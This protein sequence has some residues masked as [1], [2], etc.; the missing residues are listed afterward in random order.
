MSIPELKSAIREAGLDYSDCTEKNELIERARQALNILSSK[1][2]Q[3]E[4]ISAEGYYQ[5]YHVI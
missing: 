3:E 5:E 1:S 4:C 2:K